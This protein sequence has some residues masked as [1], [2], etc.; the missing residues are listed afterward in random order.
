M[1]MQVTAGVDWRMMVWLAGMLVCVLF[2]LWSWLR[3]MRR[4][5]EAIPMQAEAVAD[6]LNAHPLKR[7]VRVCCCEAVSTPLT[8]ELLRPVILLPKKADAEGLEMILC[9]EW[10]HIRSMDVLKKAIIAAAVCVH[11]FNPLAWAMLS[12]SNRDI[13]LACDEQTLRICGDRRAYAM[14]LIAMEEA[15][16]LSEPRV[17]HFFKNQT[18]ERIVAIMKCRNKSILSIILA[19]LLVPCS[20]VAFATTAPENGDLYAEYEPFG[21]VYDE[22]EDCLYFNG[23]Q[24]RYFEDL[25]PVGDSGEIAGIV[26][27]D[28]NGVV[29][30]HAVRDL[31]SDIV[32][33]EDGSFDPSG[34]LTG[35]EAYSQEE[36][37]ARTEEIQNA[38]DVPYTAERVV[39]VTSENGEVEYTET[40]PYE[41]DGPTSVF[42]TG[43]DGEYSF[44][45]NEDYVSYSEAASVGIIGGA[46][47][48]TSIY[49]NAEAE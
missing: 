47:G 27:N 1:Q 10:M 28:S 11:W 42:I 45:L 6:F 20:A 21:L 33:N 23:Q 19:V 32:R 39:I 36:F 35:V 49:I 15:R 3:S 4:F 16:G 37:D 31:S 17:N 9:H 22:R 41:N 48:P 46:D 43:G 14:T 5:R 8:Y 12:L 34:V 7:K 24:I 30:V 2:F 38:V 40:H 25:Y 18:E 44:S 29:D 26:F 13:E